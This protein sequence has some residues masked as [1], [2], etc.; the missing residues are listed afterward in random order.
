[1]LADMV[2]TVLSAR[3]VLTVDDKGVSGACLRLRS[4]AALGGL[5]AT[6][7][8]VTGREVLKMR[9]VPRRRE[10]KLACEPRTRL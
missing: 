8:P 10:H 4:F 6:Q 3:F 1:M 7:A 9:F 2:G 5:K